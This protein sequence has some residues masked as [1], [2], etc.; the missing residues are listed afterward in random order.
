MNFEEILYRA[1]QG[2]E[3]AINQIVEM[4]RPLLIKSALVNGRFDEDLFQELVVETLKCI[5]YYR[6]R[7]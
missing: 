2:D 1:Q 3:A 5:Q 4:Y 6:E 7:K